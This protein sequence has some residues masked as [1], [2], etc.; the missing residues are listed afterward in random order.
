MLTWLSVRDLAIVEAL[1]LEPSPGLNII[2]GET[3]AGKSILVSAL[4]L[5][6]GA[7]ARA[8]VVRSGADRAEVQAAFDLD[9]SPAL[10]ERVEALLDAPAEELV[11][12]RVVKA[13]GRS[14]AWVNGVLVPVGT[15]ADLVHGVIDICSQHEHDQLADPGSHL[16]FLDAFAE[17]AQEAS[18]MAESWA[19]LKQAQDALDALAARIRDRTEREALVR[20]QLEE[21][22][23]V[24]P[25]QG[26]EESLEDE[27]GRLAHAD[28]LRSA[29]GQAEEALYAGEDAAGSRL[30]RVGRQM[31]GVAGVDPALDELVARLDEVRTAVEE[32]GRDLGRY[33]RG[34][35]HDPRRLAVVEERLGALRRLTR[36]FGGTP[37]RLLAHRDALR[38]ELEAFD[39]LE[40]QL[41]RLEA[42]RHRAHDRA[43]ASARTLSAARREAAAS[44]GRDITTQLADL[45]MGDARVE[46]D[47]ARRERRPEHPE[48]DGARLGPHGI[49]RAELLIAP[50]RGEPPRPLHR[51]ASGGELSRSL[52]AIKQVLAARAP[53]GLY[54]FDEV[55]TGV[56]GAVAEAIGRKLADIARHQQV[57]CITHQPQIA[58]YGASHWH[59]RKVRGDE[60]TSSLLTRLDDGGRQDEL[61][62]MLGGMEVTDAAH[63]AARDLLARAAL[64]A[65]GET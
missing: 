49:D 2:T 42:D 61:A 9:Q 18:S 23:A 15:L 47:L 17:V 3:G 55:D 21:I 7:R 64:T 30:A 46:V 63:A 8:D 58:A 35:V 22:D 39:S 60:R 26:E 50:N 31:Q 34:V 59:V 48:V 52:L 5:A 25:T 29:A 16:R 37:E 1:E 36:R 6:L 43:A 54:V 65:G 12:R 27:L 11:I 38:A 62:R 28:R 20:M 24:D 53:R 10:R 19:T 51:I 40:D 33:G 56:G 45:G 57:L 13:E 14:R 4:Q 44:L 41:D 32:L